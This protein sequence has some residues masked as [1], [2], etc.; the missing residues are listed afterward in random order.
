V[1]NVALDAT[2]YL[3]DVGQMHTTRNVFKDDG[4]CFGITRFDVPRSSLQA[5]H[6]TLFQEVLSSVWEL[7][8]FEIICMC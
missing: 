8:V 7:L 6:E 3:L 5:L 1:F 2:N 4:P